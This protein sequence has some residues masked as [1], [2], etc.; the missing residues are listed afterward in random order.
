MEEEDLTTT[1][2]TGYYKAY[3]K[4]LLSLPVV[5]PVH[6]YAPESNK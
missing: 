5:I 4:P 2:H 3:I 1:L 6:K